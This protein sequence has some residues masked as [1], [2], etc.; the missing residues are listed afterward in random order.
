MS[1]RDLKRSDFIYNLSQCPIGPAELNQ[2]TPDF[3]V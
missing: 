3:P 2:N 1:I